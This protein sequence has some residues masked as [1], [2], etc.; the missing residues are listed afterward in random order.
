MSPTPRLHV[1]A[2]LSE[3]GRVSLG[4]AQTHYLVNVMRRAAGGRIRLFNAR[5]GEFES[6]VEGISKKSV[7]VRVGACLRKSEASSDLQL[8]FA[9]V[10]RDAVDLIAQ[11]AT[12][13]GV[14]VLQPVATERAS[15]ARVN[16]ARLRAIATE[17]AEQSGR[18]S[19][20]EL[21][22]LAPLA[23]LLKT[24]PSERA[25]IFCDEAGDD[26]D[27]EWGG[28]HGRAAPLPE[29]LPALASQPIAVL[30]GPEGGFS[31]AE[32]ARLRAA[33]F[34]RAAGLGP[35]ILRADTAALAALALT[36]ALAGDWRRD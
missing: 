10:K 5:D 12:E 2:A 7:S 34:V 13:L 17:A 25:L 1:D 33:P 23:D 18:L 14:A 11:K 27:A 32:R 6:V 20:P 21:R 15:A 22:E 24:W 29:I 26:P 3:G 19:V 35:R 28:P 8:L 36:Q 31:P 30:I 16:T 4:A 9:P